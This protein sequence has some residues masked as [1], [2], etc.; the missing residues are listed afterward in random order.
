MSVVWHVMS[1]PIDTY[2]CDARKIRLQLTEIIGIEILHRREE[3]KLEE[4]IGSCRYLLA[5]FHPA[6]LMCNVDSLKTAWIPESFMRS[7]FGGQKHCALVQNCHCHANDVERLFSNRN[8]L[9]TTSRRTCGS[10]HPTFE[11]CWVG[12]GCELYCFRQTELPTVAVKK[13]DKRH[14]AHCAHFAH[15]I[16]LIVIVVVF[17]LSDKFFKWQFFFGISLFVWT[18]HAYIMAPADSFRFCLRSRA[19]FKPQVG[20]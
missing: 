11:I 16:V 3:W 8:S 18:I 15:C 20:L 2:R 4:L 1:V 6:A 12:D 7:I 13:G 9:S 5:Y 14:C 10:S 19:F 17:C